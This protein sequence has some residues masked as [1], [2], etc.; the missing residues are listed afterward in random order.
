MNGDFLHNLV[1][2]RKKECEKEKN[3]ARQPYDILAY[4]PPQS[5][6][7]CVLRIKSDPKMA[8]YTAQIIDG[9]SERIQGRL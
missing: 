9:T 4:F 3:R 8:A 5:C 1:T 2:P 6:V 7:L